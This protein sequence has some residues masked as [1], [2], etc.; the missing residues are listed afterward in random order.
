MDTPKKP[1]VHSMKRRSF[2]H[3]YSYRGYFHVT[4]STAEQLRQPLGR[5]CGDISKPN[6]DADAPHVELTPLGLMVQRELLTSIKRHYPMIEVDTYV[7]MPEHLHILLHATRDIFS[8]N[9]NRTHLGRVIAGFKQG[10][11]RRYWEMTGRIAATSEGS[12]AEQEQNTRQQL[13]LATKSPG[14]IDS[15]T[16]TAAP[17]GTQEAAST[18]ATQEAGI[19]EAAITPATQEAGTQEAAST[20]ATRKAGTQE[21]AST[22]ATQEATTQEAAITPATQEAGTQEAAFTP[23]TQEAAITPIA[24]PNMAVDTMP[25][26][27][28]D[29]VVEHAPSPT[30]PLPPLFEPGYCDVIPIDEAQLT[31]QRTYIRNNPRSRLLRTSNRAS[32]MPRRGG[33]DTAVSLSAMCGY[34]RRVCTATQFT[35]AIWQQLQARF[36]TDDGHICCDSYGDRQLLKRRLLPVVCHRK[37][38]AL[39]PTQKMRCLEAAAQGAILVSARIAR[40]EQEI[41]DAALADNYPVIRIIDNGFSKHYHPSAELIDAC[42]N[43]LLLLVSPWHFLFRR[44]DV[45]IH[46]P[47]CKAMNCIVQALCKTKDD[48]WKEH[49]RRNFS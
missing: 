11:N 38:A 20:P 35:P 33:I 42:T 23:A 21:A 3:E 7:I 6:G 1:T 15:T 43:S 49:D 30:A 17:A 28:N 16:A 32:L 5:V 9:G 19:Q 31:T 47:F 26:A 22:P 13:N 2:T 46:V 18:P 36:L 40:G 14:A 4:I 29:S 41:M 45:A 27:L 8:S 12:T 25:I 24:Y 39:Y 48:W 37:D 44:K 34:L 10:C